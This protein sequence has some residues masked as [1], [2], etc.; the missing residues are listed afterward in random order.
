MKEQL[1][2]LIDF[3]RATQVHIEDRP[4]AD[5]PLEITELRL[6]LLSEELEEYRQAVNS[7]DLIEVADALTD[8]LYVLLGTMVSHGLQEYGAEL[9]DE[10]HKSNMSKFDANS[11]PIHR[12]DGKVLKPA[13]FIKPN[14]EGILNQ[15]K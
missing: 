5:L 7:K 3:H 1:E 9:F 13:S 15:Q 8:L 4:T 10:V 14:I 11:G 2:K 6:S 12:Q